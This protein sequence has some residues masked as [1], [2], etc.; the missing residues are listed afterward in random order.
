MDAKHVEKEAAR[1]F[2]SQG[3]SLTEIVTLLK[4]SKSSVS[5]WIRDVPV[6]EQFTQAFRNKIRKEK[7]TVKDLAKQKRLEEK[8]ITAEQLCAH[9][10]SVSEIGKPIL[11]FGR[12]ISGDGR[13]MV[14]APSEYK[15]KTYIGH[16][17][18]YEHRLIMERALDKL[19]EPDEVVHHLN[20]NKLDNR[21]DNLVIVTRSYHGSIHAKEPEVKNLTCDFCKTQ[22]KRT[23]RRITSA[24]VQ[25]YKHQFCCLSH[26][27]SFQQ[28]ERWSS[29]GKNGAQMV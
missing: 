6:P 22:F 18:V 21:L 23:Q 1:K 24:T 7:E 17:Y 14:P 5:L 4:V 19:L 20:G 11:T 29:P 27:V 15:G 16:R 25:G 28:K 13:W 26:A 3:K 12:L 2:R 9:L 8:T 10:N